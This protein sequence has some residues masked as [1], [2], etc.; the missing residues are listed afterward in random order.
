[1]LTVAEI[2]LDEP[3]LAFAAVLEVEP[4]LQAARK[5]PTAQTAPAAVMALKLLD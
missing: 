2:V 5:T 4:L 1:L 3:P